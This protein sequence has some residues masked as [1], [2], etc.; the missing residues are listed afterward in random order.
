MSSTGGVLAI[1]S[2]CS[3][4]AAN[5]MC[6]R[7]AGISTWSSST[8]TTCSTRAPA[9]AAASA[10]SGTTTATA[11]RS[12]SCSAVRARTRPCSRST[13]GVGSRASSPSASIDSNDA[14]SASRQAR[15][16]SI[17]S[18]LRP[19][20]LAQQLEDI[21]HLVGELRDLG[22]AHGRA[23]ALERV[24]R[25]EDLVDRLAVLGVLLQTDD[26]QVQFLQV[27]LRLGQ[28]HGHVFGGVHYA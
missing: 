16:V 15:T 14:V 3:P 17:A 24:S 22:E 6:A 8:A 23:H 4:I 13:S 7:T 27:L 26:G 19:S 18:R 12:S 1:S 20:P 2:P 5:A 25:A 10:R 9:A 28:E 21:L 11:T